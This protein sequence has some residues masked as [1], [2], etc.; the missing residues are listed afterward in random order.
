MRLKIKYNFLRSG[1]SFCYWDIFSGLSNEK[2][3]A[4]LYSCIAS[5]QVY[6]YTKFAVMND[7]KGVPKKAI[8]FYLPLLQRYAER[9]I[10]DKAVAG[11]I[12][13]KV[14]NDQYDPDRQIPSPRLRKVLQ[15]ATRNRCIYYN[16]SVIFDRPVINP[17]K[18][19]FL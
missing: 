3:G 13:Q 16:Q 4:A 8:V 9:L 6:P 2:S 19:L 15:T 10:H 14:L 7:L 12:V 11:K 1:C 5:C 18:T 17:H